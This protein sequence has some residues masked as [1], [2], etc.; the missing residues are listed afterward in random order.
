MNEILKTHLIEWLIRYSGGTWKSMSCGRHGC[1]AHGPPKVG[2]KLSDELRFR[3]RA[4]RSWPNA[5]DTRSGSVSAAR[6]NVNKPT[7]PN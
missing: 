2:Y 3:P 4:V 6:M 1:S 5:N 7:I